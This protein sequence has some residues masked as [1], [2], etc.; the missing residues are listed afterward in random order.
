MLTELFERYRDQ[1]SDIHGHL[2]YMHDLCVDLDAQ[3]VL[4]LGVRTGL[5]TAAFLHAM[6]KTG[7][8]VVSVDVNACTPDP[9]IADHPRWS[10]H[11]G[12]DLDFEPIECDVL[13]I[14]TSHAYQ[15]TADE[16]AR[17]AP[18]AQVVLLHD[19]C[20]AQPEQ[21]GPQPQFPVRKAALEYLEA[22]PGWGWHE[23]EHCW[24]LGVLTRIGESWR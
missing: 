1:P 22:N 11:Q 4:E 5:S 19:T 20:L 8:R 14:D 3:T 23:F 21:V 6:D 18:H 16:L 7:G 15:H 17:F 12:N 2:Q 9:T 13:F 10:F 24:G